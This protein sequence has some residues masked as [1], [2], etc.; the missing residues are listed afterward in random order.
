M[1]NAKQYHNSGV[2][3]TTAQ[4]RKLES[5]AKRLGV[6]ANTVICQLVENAELEPVQRVEAVARLQPSA[7]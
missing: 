5:M 2:R 6:S 1:K 3:F 4:K 7:G